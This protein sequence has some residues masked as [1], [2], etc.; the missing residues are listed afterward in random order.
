MLIETDERVSVL[1][2]TPSA[3]QNPSHHPYQILSSM[4]PFP[5]VPTPLDTGSSVSFISQLLSEALQ[6]KLSPVDSPIKLCLGDGHTIDIPPKT[7][8]T[9]I[10]F[11]GMNLDHEFHVLNTGHAV[12]AGRDLISKLGFSLS[13]TPLALKVPNAET[14]V[15]VPTDEVL[16]IPHA[17]QSRIQENTEINN[18]L[19]ELQSIHSFCSH[20]EALFHAKLAEGTQPIWRRQYPIPLIYHQAVSDQVDKWL[21]NGTIR[22]A[23]PGCPWNLPLT[24]APKRVVGDTTQKTGRRVCIDPTA[25]NPYVESVNFQL[26][27]IDDLLRLYSQKGGCFSLIYI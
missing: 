3:N 25:V 14:S 18:L 20:P 12:V 27:R 5:D 15:C 9:P 4:G 11:A 23:D 13:L 21:S 19:S 8:P 6:L 10:R 26:P 22:L 2:A 1:G 7:P 16:S 17:E 24:T